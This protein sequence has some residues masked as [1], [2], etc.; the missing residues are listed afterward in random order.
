MKKIIG[1][2]LGI[3]IAQIVNA[4]VFTKLWEW[5]I[6]PIFTIQ[7]VNLLQAIGIM[8]LVNFFRLKAIKIEE[9]QDNFWER[10]G[11][12]LAQSILVA[13]ITLFLGGIVTLFL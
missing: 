8:I 3:I 4:F 5:F 2:F 12:N 9:E 13:I 1:I 10:F 6:V 7:P 11:K